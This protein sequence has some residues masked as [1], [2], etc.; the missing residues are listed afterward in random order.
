MLEPPEQPHGPRKSADGVSPTHGWHPH[1]GFFCMEDKVLLRRVLNVF[2]VTRKAWALAVLV[3]IGLFSKLRWT[4]DSCRRR[5]YAMEYTLVTQLGNSTV[6]GTSR[7][8]IL[9]IPRLVVY[10]SPHECLFFTTGAMPA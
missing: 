2:G 3:D 6:T 7:E 5:N 10:T 4:I 9:Y 8:Y 1:K